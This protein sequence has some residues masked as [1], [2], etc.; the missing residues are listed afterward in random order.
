MKRKMKNEEA[1]EREGQIERKRKI[2][3]EKDR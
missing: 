2:E 3:R 1:E